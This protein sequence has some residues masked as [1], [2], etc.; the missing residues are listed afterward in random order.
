MKH[1]FHRQW[2]KGKKYVKHFSITK[3]NLSQPF[4][5][6]GYLADKSHVHPRNTAV[7][8]PATS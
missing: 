5:L 8:V 1:E 2:K 3:L 4:N 7:W 6:P